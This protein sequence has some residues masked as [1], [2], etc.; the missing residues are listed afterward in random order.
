MKAVR[1]SILAAVLALPGAAPLRMVIPCADPPAPALET[2]GEPLLLRDFEAPTD[3]VQVTVRQ[4]CTA[5]IR[6]DLQGGFMRDQGQWFYVSFEGE[7]GRQMREAI[8]QGLEL[9]LGQ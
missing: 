9:G 3:R 5:P 7:V 8:R 2:G 1:L 4:E 6:I